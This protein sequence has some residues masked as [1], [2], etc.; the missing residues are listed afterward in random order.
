M[1]RPF[2][3][4]EHQDGWSCQRRTVSAFG[5]KIK[6]AER[7]FLEVHGLTSGIPNLIRAGCRALEAVNRAVAFDDAMRINL[8]GLRNAEMVQIC[9]AI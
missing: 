9:R 5:Q 7:A 1:P 4:I 2:P 6:Q 8:A 3:V